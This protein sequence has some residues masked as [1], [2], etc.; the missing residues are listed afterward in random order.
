[1]KPPFTAQQGT[2]SLLLIVLLMTVSPST[3]LNVSL[4]TIVFKRRFELNASLL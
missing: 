3:E 4:P 2:G 1:M